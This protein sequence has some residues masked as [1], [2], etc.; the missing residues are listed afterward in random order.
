MKLQEACLC[1]E[2]REGKQVGNCPGACKSIW[3]DRIS[4]G[5]CG[6]KLPDEM[7][8]P[9]LWSEDPKVRGRSMAGLKGAQAA[10]HSEGRARAGGKGR[11]GRAGCVMP[12]PRAGGGHRGSSAAHGAPA[13]FSRHRRV[14]SG[15]GSGETATASGA[16]QTG[17]AGWVPMNP[18]LIS[19][20]LASSPLRLGLLTCNLRTKMPAPRRASRAVPA[21]ASAQG[22]FLSPLVSH[23]CS[24]PQLGETLGDDDVGGARPSS[25]ALCPRLLP[26][27][28]ARSAS[29]PGKGAGPASAG[30]GLGGRAP[31]LTQASQAPLAAP[32]RL[33]GR[34][35]GCQL[36]AG[37]RQP[38]A[39]YF[40]SCGCGPRLA[41]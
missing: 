11:K 39:S 15:V 38:E 2:V 6:G 33:A 31:A 37:E 10:F 29:R 34:G 30:Q 4:A 13:D 32:S 21:W 23:L 22:R 35:M 1:A 27:R 17:L 25:R 24:D 36:P 26:S 12:S 14:G 5:R 19:C 3:R 9:T 7:L 41:T 28:I 8:G 16:S 40:G 18:R 20:D